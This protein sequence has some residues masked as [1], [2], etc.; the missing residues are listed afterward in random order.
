MFVTKIDVKVKDEIMDTNVWPIILFY[1]NVIIVIFV[2]AAL[3]DKGRLKELVPIGLFIAVENYTFDILGLHFGY[4]SYPLEN[5]GYPE[6]PIISSIV[7]FPLLAM[8]FYQFLSKRVIKNAFLI[9]GF[10]VYNMIIEVLSIKTTDIFVYHKNMNLII[11]LIVYVSI[12]F[13]IIFVGYLYKKLD[14]IPN[15]RM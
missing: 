13:V 15:R 10:V 5:P 1:G 4:W 8:L 14:V 2:F 6:V 12:Y 3:V 7:Y 9:G 11:A